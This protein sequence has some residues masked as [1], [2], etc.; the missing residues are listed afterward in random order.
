MAIDTMKLHILKG[1]IQNIYLVEYD[2]GLLLLD[3]CCRPDIKTVQRFIEDDLHRALSDLKLVVVTH[4]H[5]DHAGGAHGLRQLTGCKIASGLSQR[6]WYGGVSGVLMHLTDIGLSLYMASRLGRPL[7]NLWYARKLKPDLS[8]ADGD[9]LP[10]F[11]DWRVFD[12][13]G[14]T[15]RDISLMHE[16]SARIYVADLIVKVRQKFIT[17]WPLFHPNRYRASAAKV[18]QLQPDFVLLAHG[19]EIAVTPEHACFDVH[20][21]TLP[22]THWRAVKTRVRQVLLRT[23]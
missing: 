11:N 15:D 21:P 23:K 19:G 8:L 12:T 6:H 22:R 16:P 20:T 14:H 2:H 9:T 13:H 3:G 10:G 5:P 17:P 18:K 7:K 4:M 1:Y